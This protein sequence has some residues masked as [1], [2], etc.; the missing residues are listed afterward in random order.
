MKKI[1][2]LLSAVIAVVALSMTSCSGD[3]KS[4]DKKSGDKKECKIATIIDFNATW[5]GPC[6]QFAPIFEAAAEKYGDKIEF[7]SV[8]VDEDPDLANQYK[9]ESIPMVVLLDHKGNV[10]DSYVGYMDASQFDELIN[11]NL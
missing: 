7:K 2:L 11:S 3:K 1:M 8:D 10:L 4:D 5:C 9:V 6:K